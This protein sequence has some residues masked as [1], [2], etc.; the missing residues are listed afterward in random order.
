[1]AAEGLVAALVEGN[2]GA[3]VEVNSETDFVARNDKFQGFVAGVAKLA[4]E[5]KDLPDLMARTLPADGKS[6]ADKLTNLIATIG[7]NMSLR[8]MAAVSV[9]TGTVAA[10]VHNALAPGLGKIGVLVGLESSGDKAKLAALGKQL[11][12]HV[13]AAN[14]Q[15]LTAE[16][17]DAAAVE[18]ERAILAEKAKASGKPDKVVGMMVEGGLRKFYEDVVLLEQTYV[19]DGESKVKDVI[20]KAAK[21][22][23]APVKVAGFVRMALGEGIERTKE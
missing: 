2:R 23:G 11:A 12:M 20:E 16:A 15:A 1:V 4:L 3:V 13:A 19:I 6:V 18:R 14:P 22:M 21:E 17:V 10:Y 5:S 9:G 7:E 8:R